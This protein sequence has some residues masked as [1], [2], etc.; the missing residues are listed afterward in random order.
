V[1]ILD[2]YVTVT[3][4]NLFP[5]ERGE[6]STHKGISEPTDNDHISWEQAYNKVHT[7]SIDEAKYGLCL[8]KTQPVSLACPLLDCRQLTTWHL[9]T[10]PHK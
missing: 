8:L 1:W 6:D 2:P 4:E 7:T 9:P 10:N 3:V 5:R